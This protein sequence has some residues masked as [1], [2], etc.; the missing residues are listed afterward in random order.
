MLRRYTVIGISPEHARQCVDSLRV[1]L[2]AMPQTDET[3]PHVARLMALMDAL[4]SMA[5]EDSRPFD[6]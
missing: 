5:A 2:A 6:R 3:E 4:M 1:V